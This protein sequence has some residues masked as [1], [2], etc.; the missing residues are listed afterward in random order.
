MGRLADWA[1]LRFVPADVFAQCA[2][3]AFRVARAEDGAGN[4][5]ALRGVREDVHKVQRELLG[6]V[7]DQDEVAVLAE[8]FLFVRFDLHLGWRACRLRH[9]LLRIPLDTT[10]V[11]TGRARKAVLAPPARSETA[12]RW[13][14]FGR[15]S[16]P[17]FVDGGSH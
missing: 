13:L 1:K 11:R 16:V 9:F 10:I 17:F 15:P 5:L 4:Q 2:P 14:R 8:Q 6:V 7:I 12:Q 3:E